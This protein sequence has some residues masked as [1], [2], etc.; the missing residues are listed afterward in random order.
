MRVIFNSSVHAEHVIGDLVADRCIPADDV[1]QFRVF[2]LLDLVPAEV[3]LVPEAVTVAKGLELP[4]ERRSDQRSDM[5]T[6]H[7]IFRQRSDPEIDIVDRCVDRRQPVLDV[8]VGRDV[9]E[10]LRP[11]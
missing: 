9:A 10:V 6:R 8:L 5:A 4:L 11:S 1:G 3:S 7:G 2:Q